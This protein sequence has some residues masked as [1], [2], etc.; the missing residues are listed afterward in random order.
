MRNH[1]NIFVLSEVSAKGWRYPCRHACWSLLGYYSTLARAEATLRAYASALAE[2]DEPCREESVLGFQIVERSVDRGLYFISGR[3]YTPDGQLF[4][5]SLTSN[6]GGMEFTGRE[7]ADIRFHQGD[8][9]EVLHGGYAELGIVQSPPPDKAYWAA[10]KQEYADWFMDDTDD[11]YLVFFLGEGD[12]HW[13]PQC[14]DVFSPS[15]PV[16]PAL[17]RKLRDKLTE[18][19]TYFGYNKH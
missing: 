12:T 13:H 9:V 5:E 1:N 10:K 7:P 8:I 17:E 6:E 11:C 3:S 4:S 19:Q 14:Y 2:D 15:K 16:S 18:M